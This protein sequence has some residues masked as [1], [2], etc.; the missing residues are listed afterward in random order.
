MSSKNE[1]KKLGNQAL[2][3]GMSGRAIFKLLFLFFL[4]LA[5]A[6]ANAQQTAATVH[7]AVADPDAAVIPGATVTL[8]PASG[9]ALI[10]KSQ[11]D[12]SYAF[13]NV[14]AGTY[15]LTVTMD[16]FATFVKQG[17]HV[18]AG[19]SVTIDAKMAVQV[20]DQQVQVTAQTAQVSVDQDSNASAT[21]I[22]GKDLDALSDD[23][24]ELS[25]EL[26]ALAGPAAGPNGGQIY[27][28]GFTGGQLPPKSSIREIRI[29]Q[30]PFSAQY[31][32][33]GFGRVE[34]F[35]KPGTDK[36][37]GSA[38]LNGNASAFNTSSP[39]LDPSVVQPP[40]HT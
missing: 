16:G 32:R 30:N 26:T 29:N 36:F 1:I 3:E 11:S 14:P 15:S 10:E 33:L 20:A 28:D 8:T 23:P 12:G 31:D 13:H 7:G 18:A 4:A 27:V 38:Q 24:D 17:V 40:Y 5:S 37:H 39:F 25:S 34:V 19:Q 35:T 21:V 6:S 9:K 22:K 2:G